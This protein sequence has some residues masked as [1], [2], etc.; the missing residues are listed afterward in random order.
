MSK[1]TLLDELL[2]LFEK[3]A[4]DLSPG[5]TRVMEWPFIPTTQDCAIAFWL[6]GLALAKMN[7]RNLTSSSFVIDQHPKRRFRYETSPQAPFTVACF[8]IL[9]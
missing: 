2:E 5:E 8:F 9:F 1:P 7:S 3:P 4:D 6:N